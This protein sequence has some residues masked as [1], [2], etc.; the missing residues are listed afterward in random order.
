MRTA[1]WV[2]PL[3]PTPQTG[4]DRLTVKLLAWSHNHV[5]R[6]AQA[7]NEKGVVGVRW[8]PRLM[9]IVSPLRPFLFPIHGLDR[10]IHV[11][12]PGLAQHWF[13]TPQQMSTLPPFERLRLLPLE[14]TSQSILAQ[15]PAHAQARRIDC[16]PAQGRHMRIAPVARQNRQ[17]PG[18]QHIGPTRG[19]GTAVAQWT[20]GCPIN[21]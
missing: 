19:I 11:A 12:N 16:V 8:P 4:A 15:H 2:Q 7:R 14:R 13:Y 9:R 17:G 5:Q 20:I 21:E 18:P 6:Q 10:N 1:P 3:P